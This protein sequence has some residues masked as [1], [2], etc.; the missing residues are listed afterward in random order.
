MEIGRQRQEPSH[1]E[2]KPTTSSVQHFGLPKKRMT[3]FFYANIFPD[4]SSSGVT[5]KVLA[6]VSALRKMGHKVFLT[7]YTSTGVLILNNENVVVYARDFSLWQKVVPSF[8]RR[9]LLIRSS[10]LFLRKHPD[11]FDCVYARFHYF[12]PLYLKMLRTA[13]QNGAKNVVEAHAFPNYQLSLRPLQ[14]PLSPLM[15]FYLLDSVCN[16]Y[17]R[18]VVDLVAAMSPAEM[19]WGIKTV[20]VENAL[21]VDEFTPRRP[22]NTSDTVHVLFIAYER[23]SH[24]FDRVVVGLSRYYNEGGSR[25]IVVDF[26]GVPLPSTKDLIEKLGLSNKFLFHGPQSGKAL[27]AAYDHSDLAFGHLGNHRIGSYSGSSIKVSEYLAKGIPFVYA[28]NELR[29]SDQ[30]PFALRLPLD[31][32]PVDFFRVLAFLDGLGNP[33]DVSE[34]I[35]GYCSSL[36]RWEEQFEKVFSELD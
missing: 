4:D 6:Q 15:P 12:D 23:V 9:S 5:K 2:R 14:V 11:Q 29:V 7:G 13:R 32:S 25:D 16:G 26:V 35:R 24:G 33:K 18:K 34:K 3:V 10:L 8:F 17:A 31:D 36:P 27:D 30:F 20:R 28:W 21:N 19:I 1:A 22:D